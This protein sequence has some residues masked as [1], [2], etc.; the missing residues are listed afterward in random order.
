MAH[1]TVH[2]GYRDSAGWGSSGVETVGESE[3]T[4]GGR[5]QRRSSGRGEDGAL[6]LPD[7]PA[8]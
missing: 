1:E 4:P 7:C 8:R 6:L 2:V 3:E 5:E